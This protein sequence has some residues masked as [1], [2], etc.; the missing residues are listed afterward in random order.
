MTRSTNPPIIIIIIIII[1]KTNPDA[2]PNSNT[3]TVLTL[4]RRAISIAQLGRLHFSFR[5]NRPPNCYCMKAEGTYKMHKISELQNHLDFFLQKQP[6]A[7]SNST[8][9][10]VLQIA[11]P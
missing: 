5:R 9:V 7:H 6:A 4:N 2:N 11:S 8:Q 3:L 1:I 10:V